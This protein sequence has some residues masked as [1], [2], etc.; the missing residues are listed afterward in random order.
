MTFRADSPSFRDKIR[1][2]SLEENSSDSELDFSS[3]TE[4][5]VVIHSE[6]DSEISAG[7]FSEE[8]IEIQETQSA[9]IFGEN[10]HKWS[11]EPKRH[12]G[13]TTSKNIVL[14][15]PGNKGEAKNIGK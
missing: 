9:S 6:E 7:E 12:Q 1:A 2:A 14:R 3:E 5:N 4:D 13:R 10:G 11:M 8:E 15:I